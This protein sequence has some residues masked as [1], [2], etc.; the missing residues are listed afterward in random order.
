MYSYSWRKEDNYM[1]EISFVDIISWIWDH[2][3]QI[4]VVF[5]LFF[6]ISKI[7]L[8]P[9]TALMNH[10]LRPIKKEIEDTKKELNDS[11]DQLQ[12]EIKLEI[13]SIKLEQANAKSTINQLI[14]SNEMSEISRIRWEIIEFSN[15]ISNDIKHTKDE[16]R[17]IKDEAKRYHT[18]IEKYELDNGIIDE[19][20]AKINDR[21]EKNK[22]GTSVY[23]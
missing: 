20:M 5:S 18:L 17:H 14:E 16:Y 6:E 23:F 2:A 13:E 10:I 3:I 8:N 9:I 11:I 19:E 1:G 21:Y 15:S 7:K 12:S 22:N 4:L